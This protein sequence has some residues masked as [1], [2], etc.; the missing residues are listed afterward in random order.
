MLTKDEF[1]R[2]LVHHRKNEIVIT[3]M[4]MVRPWAKH[5]DHILDF[6]VADSAMGHAADFALGVALARPHQTV[7]CLNGDGSMLM[8]L[9]TLVTIAQSGAENLVLFV[10]QNECYEITGNQPVPGATQID[11]VLLAH[12]A[13]IRRAYFFD[14]PQVYSASLP[15]LLHGTGP[16][17]AAVRVE[18]GNEKPLHRSQA[19][20]ARYLRPSL[21]ESAHSF[22]EILSKQDEPD[23][24]SS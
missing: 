10:I 15:D 12:G 2:P 14:D 7:I 8:N 9:G 16:V 22:R 23:I 5:S 17:L 11:Y 1:I 18:A 19:E 21:A 13:G 24:V 3:S 4:G 6:A 20:P